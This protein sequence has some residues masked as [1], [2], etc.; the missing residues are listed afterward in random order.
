MEGGIWV[1]R[2]REGK[3]KGRGVKGKYGIS[4]WEMSA[5]EGRVEY[6]GIE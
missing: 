1:E 4:E 3:S 6:Q 2:D 5:E